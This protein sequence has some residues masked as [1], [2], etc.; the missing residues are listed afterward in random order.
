MKKQLLDWFEEKPVV[1]AAKSEGELQRCLESESRVIFLLF[2][3]KNFALI[4][5][6][7]F[8]QMNDFWMK[9]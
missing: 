8:L 2:G 1:A 9:D 6:L 5:F 3:K 7:L 4:F